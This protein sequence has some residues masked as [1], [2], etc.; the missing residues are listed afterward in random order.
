MYKWVLDTEQWGQGAAEVTSINVFLNFF[1][2][3]IPD[4]LSNAPTKDDSR[5][6]GPVAT[7]TIAA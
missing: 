5:N 1:K 7:E 3:P 2:T 4:T 6:N